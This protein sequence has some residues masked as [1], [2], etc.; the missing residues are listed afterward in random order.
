MVSGRVNNGILRRHLT[1]I[2][3][4]KLKVISWRQF[5]HFRGLRRLRG[6]RK[7]RPLSVFRSFVVKGLS[8]KLIYH[9][10]S[11]TC[12]ATALFI[13]SLKYYRDNFCRFWVSFSIILIFKLKVSDGLLKFSTLAMQEYWPPILRWV[14]ERIYIL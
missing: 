9:H 4:A 13:T 14:S 8:W 11:S 3:P 10:N 2:S 7:L 5:R 12:I 6:L 1:Y